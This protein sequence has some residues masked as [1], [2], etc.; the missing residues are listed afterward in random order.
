MYYHAL[1]LKARTVLI[2]KQEH[3]AFPQVPLVPGCTIGAVKTCD[4]RV[5]EIPDSK[6][7]GHLPT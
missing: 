1:K 5:G 2:N 3:G 7:F 6:L 4:H